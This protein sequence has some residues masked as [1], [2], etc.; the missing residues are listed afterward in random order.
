MARRHILGPYKSPPLGADGEW[1]EGQA[2][3]RRWT[4]KR[5]KEARAQANQQARADIARLGAYSHISALL[6]ALES[7]P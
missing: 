4:E 7:K 1:T 5:N 6:D 3:L 2:S